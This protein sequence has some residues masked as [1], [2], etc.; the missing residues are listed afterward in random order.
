MSPP[1]GGGSSG[2][3]SLPTCQGVPLGCDDPGS[4]GGGAVQQPPAAGPAAAATGRR[5]SR[6]LRTV[7]A[8]DAVASVEV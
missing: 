8:A 5:Q 7:G 3:Q 1:E 2:A 6:G 4:P